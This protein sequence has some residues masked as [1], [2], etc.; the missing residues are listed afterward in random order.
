MKLKA[1]RLSMKIIKS[2]MTIV[3]DEK[4]KQ[5]RG[6]ESVNNTGKNIRR[7][8]HEPQQNILKY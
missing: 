1:W 5:W 7:G 4:S 8:S 6:I 3:N 2:L